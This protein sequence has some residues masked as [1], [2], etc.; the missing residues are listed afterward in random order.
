MGMNYRERFENAVSH[1]AVDRAPT[2]FCGTC[3]TSCYSNVIA[4]LA[5]HFNITASDDNEAIE[6]I[7]QRFDTDFRRVGGMF[8]PDSEYKDYSTMDKGFYT[9]CWGIKRKF[10]G[11]YWDIVKS[12][13]ADKELDE[14]KGYKWPSITNVPKEF[15]RDITET[16]K[17]FYHDTEYVIAAEHP[18]L[19]FLEHGCW[20]FGF[21]DFFYRLMAEPDTIEWFFTNYYQY[22]KEA[23][24]VYYGAIGD[25]IHVT[26]S[27]DD[28][29]TQ[30]GSFI[31]PELFGEHIR[32]WY[33][34]RIALTKELT[35]AKYFHHSC[36]SVY[37]LLDH[38]IDMGVDILN[39]I[40]PGVFEMEPE[41][42]KADFGDRIA[43]WGGVD[44][45]GLLSNGTPEQVKAQMIRLD[46]I[47][48]V[49]GGWIVSP[50]HNIQPDV[51]AQNIIAMYNALR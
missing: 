11:M 49:N 19:G 21:E 38:I 23:C 41:R 46:G 51:P 36:G 16:T 15:M 37:R 44:E 8:D 12:P 1:K 17:R 6:H 24:E 45:Q 18:V 7:Q 35:N 10:T 39:P 34:K 42:L 13:F 4:D 25:Y 28:F 32:P 40:Q 14:L 33:E 5:K 43:F 31:S 29:G 2:D 26:T 30:H 47:L 20:I 48:N 22:V 27:G 50:S 9:D 3:L